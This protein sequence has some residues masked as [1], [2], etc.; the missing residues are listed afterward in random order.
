MKEFAGKHFLLIVE[1]EAVPFDR[2]VWLQALTLK[3]YGA[4]VTVICPIFGKDNKKYETIDNIDIFRYKLTFSDGTK[5]GYAKEYGT[6]FIKSLILFHKVILRKIK[7]FFSNFFG[8]FV[9][10]LIITM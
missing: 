6:A 5:S 4:N 10:A 2:R 3:E 7:S 1:N 8:R 9:V